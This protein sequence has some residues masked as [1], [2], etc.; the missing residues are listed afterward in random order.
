MTMRLPVFACS[1]PSDWVRVAAAVLVLGLL[2]VLLDDPFFILVLQS[3]AYLFIVTLGLDILVGWTG[4]ISLGH[5]GLY[6]V[7]AYTTAIMS[8]RLGLPFWVTAPAG[9][10]LA[11]LCGAA[12]ALPSL[13]AKG[14]YLAMVTIAFGFM[15]EVTSNRWSFTGGPMGISSIPPPTLPGGS[16]M[17]ATQYFWLIAGVALLCHL[18]AANLFRSRI[19]RT[20]RAL[21]SSDIA[22]EIVGINVYR[23]KVLAFVISSVYAGIGGVFFAH[24][25]GFINSD[26]FVFSFSVS[27]LA[28]VLIGGSGT[29]YGPLV[30][31][32]ILN[33]I[34]TVFASLY[35]YHLYIFGGIILVTIV[36]L[37]KGIVGSL[38]QITWF[39]RVH[40]ETP[41]IASDACIPDFAPGSLPHGAALAIR[42]LCKSFGGIRALNGVDLAIAPGTIHGLIGPNGSGKSTLVNVLSGVYRADSGAMMLGDCALSPKRPSSM[43]RHGVTRTFQNIRL[44]N[45]LSVLDNVMVGFHL[46]FT[47]GFWRHFLQT[48]AA[49]AEEAAFR[50][51]AI[52][53]LA[54]VGIGERA[55]DRAQDLPHGQQRMLEI[56]RALAV[57]P[58]L[59]MLDEPAAGVSPAELS[60]LMR[61]IRAIR[62]AGVTLLVIEH[63]M[64][65]IMQVSD[66]ISVLDFGQKIAE[67]TAAAIC[68]DPKVIEAYLGA[69]V[70]PGE[71]VA[72][73]A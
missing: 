61:I 16:E 4:Q 36:F 45:E 72:A 62:A 37:P 32:V 27:L 54:F 28:A 66:T 30:G 60:N 23:Y 58:R 43:A 12:L 21:Q 20:F 10:A 24:Q 40:R 42:Q 11:G 48:R 8:T 6:A 51:K 47:C 44:F 29:L 14:P 33:L 18:L 26:T 13:R 7:G 46:Q 5:A 64:D 68:A 57:R 70:A 69:P 52:A 71:V 35:K 34:P 73:G 59:L 17:T 38:R 15:A 56:A 49:I 1:G 2:P 50:R 41:D 39:R 3:L 67:G 22:A 63:H 55:H 53:L 9:I 25:S 19:G 65:L 31:S